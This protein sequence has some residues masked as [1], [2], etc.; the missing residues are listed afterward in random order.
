MAAVATAA[1]NVPAIRGLAC[2]RAHGGPRRAVGSKPAGPMP[3]APSFRARRAPL[4][5]RPRRCL[6]SGQELSASDYARSG[7]PPQIPPISSPFP[8]SCA[9]SGARREP[10][11]MRSVAA[12]A[13]PCTSLDEAPARFQRG[14]FVLVQWTAPVGPVRCAQLRR[15]LVDRGWG[16]CRRDRT[17]GLARAHDPAGHVASTGISLG[18]RRLPELQRARNSGAGLPLRKERVT[19]PKKYSRVGECR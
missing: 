15:R 18:H 8:G 3:E 16:R 19:P 9:V 6:G 1:W 12:F 2:A 17:P 11:R 13:A 5:R 14:A 7:S 10:P 4:H